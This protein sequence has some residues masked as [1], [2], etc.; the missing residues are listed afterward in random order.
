MRLG[1]VG[2]GSV[3]IEG[4]CLWR[5]APP[6]EENDATHNTCEDDHTHGQPERKGARREGGGGVRRLRLVVPHFKSDGNQMG[7]KED[8]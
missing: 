7:I 3:R 6:A 2:R 1:N 4:L 5:M 8:T